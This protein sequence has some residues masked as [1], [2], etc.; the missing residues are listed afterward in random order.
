MMT[1]REGGG[2]TC[3]RAEKETAEWLRVKCSYYL[4]VIDSVQASRL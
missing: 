1:S 2:E 4:V 3:G